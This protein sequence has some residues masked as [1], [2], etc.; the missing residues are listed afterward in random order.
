MQM[1]LR[2]MILILPRMGQGSIPEECCHI[3]RCVGFP[4]GPGVTSPLCNVGY[5][6]SI[7]VQERQ[8]RQHGLSHN[9]RQLGCAPRLLSLASGACELQLLSPCAAI[10]KA[11]KS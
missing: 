9:E 2:D 6:G 4:G 8:H 11:H 3:K 10:T 1:N 5:T 7:S